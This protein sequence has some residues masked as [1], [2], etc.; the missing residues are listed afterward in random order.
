MAEAVGREG[1]PAMAGRTHTLVATRSAAE[2]MV[3]SSS[4]ALAAVIGGGALAARETARV[5]RAG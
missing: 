1:H 2:A 5:E 4:T 3:V